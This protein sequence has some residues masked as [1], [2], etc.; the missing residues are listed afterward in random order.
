[1]EVCGWHAHKN[2][3]WD[4]TLQTWHAMMEVQGM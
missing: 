1:L 4:R 3:G 2:P